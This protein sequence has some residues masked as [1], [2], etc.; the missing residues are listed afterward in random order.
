MANE[1]I[2][3]FCASSNNMRPVFYER[4]RELGTWLGQHGKT[5]VYGGNNC[6]LMEAL[7]QATKA[8]G[9]TVFGVV[10]RKL[11]DAGDISDAIDITFYCDDLHDRKQWLI[12]EP[13]IMVVLPGSVGTLDEAFSAM[14]AN[15]FG[16]HDKRIVFWN[17]EGFYDTL[18]RFLD[19]LSAE[20]V[21]NKPWGDMLSIAETLDELTQLLS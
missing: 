5:L 15:A 8:A 14:A 12:D 17:I 13:D 6:G 16:M 7:A 3:V 18:F 19:Q 2:G 4:A 20:G 11:T 21:V 10:P 9:G 1:K